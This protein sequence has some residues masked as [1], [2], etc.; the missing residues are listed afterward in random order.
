MQ[1][2]ALR[3]LYQLALSLDGTILEMLQIIEN[4][5]DETMRS[6][7]KKQTQDILGLV[8]GNIM[9]PIERILPDIVPE[10]EH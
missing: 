8:A 1:E 4:I 3:Q 7:M 10:A 6:Q 9:F 2:P 5:D